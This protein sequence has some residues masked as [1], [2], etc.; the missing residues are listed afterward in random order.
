MDGGWNS[1]TETLRSCGYPDWQIARAYAVLQNGGSV[2]EAHTAMHNVT[3]PVRANFEAE[4]LLAQ[5][6]RERVLVDNGS[7]S[8]TQN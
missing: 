4:Y 2:Q 6:G 1:V 5:A 7:K 3:I 8:K